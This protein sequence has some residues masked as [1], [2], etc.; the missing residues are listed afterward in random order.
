MQSVAQSPFEWLSGMRQTT[1]QVSFVRENKYIT[2]VLNNLRASVYLQ[3]GTYIT[4]IKISFESLFK[5]RIERV[6]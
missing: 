4:T 6:S 3:V 5:C 2:S 1:V